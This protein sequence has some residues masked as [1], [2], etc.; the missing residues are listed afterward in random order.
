[1]IVATFKMKRSKLTAQGLEEK[2]EAEAMEEMEIV[3]T[4][5]K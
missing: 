3:V 4:V 1:M 5:A 2:E